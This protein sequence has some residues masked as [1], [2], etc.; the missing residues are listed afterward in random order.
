MAMPAPRE[1]RV[2]ATVDIPSRTPDRAGKI[3]VMVTYRIGEIQSGTII[4]P[5]EDLTPEKLQ[6][7]IKA[8]IAEKAKYVGLKFTA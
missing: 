6:E 2:V 3:D 1:V 7:A 4:M 5:K 8:D